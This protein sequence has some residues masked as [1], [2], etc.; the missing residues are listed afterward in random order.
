MQRFRTGDQTLVREI[1]LSS[2]MHY[3]HS[4]APL[5][6]AQLA[7]LTGLNKSTVSSLVEEL[8]ARRLVHE[9]G[10]DASGTGRPATLLEINP[11][12][13]CLIGIELGVG[14]ISAILTDFIGRIVWRRLEE[15]DPYD[16]QAQTIQC[17]LRLVDEALDYANA[18]GVR[19]L[20]IGLTVPG[21]VD[22]D[23]GVLVFSPNLRWRDVPLGNIFQDHAGL[24][25][26]VDNDA[27]AAALGEHL[28]G[29]ARHSRDFVFVV[30]G[31]GVGGGLFLN[32]SLY[33]GTSGYAGEIGH[34]SLM[35]DQNR[36]CRCGNWGCWENVSNQYSLIERLLAR[37][38]V[39]RHSLIPKLR[40]EQD[41]P[42]TLPII[43]Q[44]AE[45]GDAEALGA[46]SE[47]GAA[48]GLGIAN[49]MNIFNPEL[50]VLGGAMSAVGEFL[51][52][53]I[54]SVI[55]QRALPDQRRQARF[56]LSA[57]GPDANVVGAVAMVVEAILSDPTRVVR[58][59]A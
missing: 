4:N 58:A 51:L 50:V 7:G 1:N 8:L 28:F 54:Q 30:A 3:L 52:P 22:I 32:G 19:L 10:L 36:P 12:A 16:Q 5:S 6:R 53:A 27:N 13:G 40:A 35:T 17:G 29:V 41:A 25:V 9:T 26:L 49:L 15:V 24:P 39:G 37:L 48:L 42:L 57:F 44:A 18:C 21:M 11:Q 45:A 47:T 23:R 34:T 38:E 43:K 56:L 2:V 46:L 20:G 59:T 55:E 14:F 33:R 31:V